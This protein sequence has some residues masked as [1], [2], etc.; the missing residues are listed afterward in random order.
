MPLAKLKS[1]MQR[2]MG[3]PLQN[4]SLPTLLI[5]LYTIHIH[6]MYR[7]NMSCIH[8]LLGRG[9]NTKNISRWNANEYW[10]NI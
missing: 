8:D 1:N 4:L 7:G 5:N 10:Y 3:V 6:T 9:Y 2:P